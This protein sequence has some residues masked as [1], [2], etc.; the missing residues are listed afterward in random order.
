MFCKRYQNKNKNGN[1]VNIEDI[2][3][4]TELYDGSI[5]TAS[6]KLSSHDETMYDLN[7][8]I[9][10][11]THKVVFDG[12]FIFVKDHPE[13]NIISDFYEE[14][15]YCI[16]TN[17]KIISIDT[18]IFCD[19]DELDEMDIMEIKVKCSEVIEECNI[20]SFNKES[21]HKHIDSGLHSDT[22]IELEDG[23][24][25]KI[26]DIC[27]NDILKY[28]ERVI[29]TVKID[30]SDMKI[31]NHSIHENKIIGTAN[32][33]VYNSDLGIFNNTL[34]ETIYSEEV[35]KNKPTVLYHLL[36]DT[37]DFTADNLNIFDYNGAIESFLDEDE[38]YIISE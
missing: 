13:S 26:K 10:S 20:E 3:L 1:N 12:D 5:V 16:N 19:W 21:I 18:M 11:G 14:Y 35:L 34:E 36:T 28:G 38:Y 9:V 6:M 2:K 27:V 7:G 30:A 17:T 32:L 25:I 23:R 33:Q 15:I 4:G 31:F 8:I 22:L 29:G 24:S 37:C